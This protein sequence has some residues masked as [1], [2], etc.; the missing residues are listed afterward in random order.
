MNNS[1]YLINLCRK[2]FCETDSVS[3]KMLIFI[4]D[5]YIN[6]SWN[7]IDSFVM[8]IAAE[9]YALPKMEGCILH[10]STFVC[11]HLY[12]HSSVYCIGGHSFSLR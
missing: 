1:V 12:V 2:C 6:D 10:L 11:P 7:W 8:V 5:N 9:L 3:F 4:V